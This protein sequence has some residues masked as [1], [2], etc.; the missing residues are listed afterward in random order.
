MSRL[1][2]F[3]LT[4]V[5]FPGMPL[6][7]NVFEERYRTL[8]AE[9]VESG[10]P[11]GVALIREGAEVGGDAVPYS[12]GTTARIVSVQ[13]AGEGRLTLTARGVR[14]FRITTLHHDR[15]FL[16]ADVE[17]P[18]DEAADVPEMLLAE[19]RA[20]LQQLQRL[21]H[22]IA[23]EYHRQIETPESPGAL[24]DAIGGAAHG[25]VQPRELQR[26]LDTLEVKRRLERAAEVLASLI[27]ATHQQAAA[28][29]AQRWA[30]P[31]RRN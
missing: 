19:T 28:V 15:P 6:T 16:S 27:T 20:R 8:V 23:N 12:T 24:A 21:R 13:P 30:S 7:L 18:V 5:L 26:L 17:Y 10:E 29:V 14:R 9:C 4:S 2:L 31:D 22:T 3:P 11:F 1:R 25:L